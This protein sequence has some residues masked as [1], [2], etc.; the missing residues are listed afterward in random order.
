MAM[1]SRYLSAL[2]IGTAAAALALTASAASAGGFAPKEQSALFLGSAFAGSA[3]G[4]ALSSMFWNPAAVGQFNGINSD[5]NYSLILPDTEITATG[6]ALFG[7]GASRS[8]GDIGDTAVLPASYMSYQLNDQIVLGMGVNAPFGLTTDG[9]FNW[10]GSR[11]ARESKITTYNFTPTV[12]YRVAPGV[13][14]GAG[15]QVEFMDAQLRQAAGAA[16]GPTAAV[17]GDDWGFGFTA[18]ILLTPT[19]TTSIGLGFRSKIE[20]ELEGTFHVSGVVPQNSI[21]ADVSLPEIVT[22]SLRQ[23]VAP[24]WTLLGT[25]EWTNWS[26]VPQLLITCQAAGA[27]ACPAANAPLVGGVLPL[28]WEDGWFVSGGLEHEYNSQLTLRGGVAWEKSP[29]QNPA[30]RTIRVPDADRIW[31]TA[32]ASYKYSENMTIDLSYAHVFV[33]DAT[34]IQGG[35]ALIGTVDSSADIISVGVRSKLDWLLSGK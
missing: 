28:G 13:T 4:G 19:S 32:G 22:L 15:L 30:G 20:H 31:V 14:V 12:A 35:G 5:S 23:Q 25:V 2:R 3:A 11:L 34:T 18:G 16:G 21:K 24:A 17:K 26:R 27:P 29:I 10:D 6:G 7:S 1:A 9:K 33:E 8:S